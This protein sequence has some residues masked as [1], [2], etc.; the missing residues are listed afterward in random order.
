MMNVTVQ[1]DNTDVDFKWICD[2]VM[3]EMHRLGVPGVAVGIFYEGRQYL[4]GFGITS[5]ENPL[6]VTADT[7]FQIGSTT[8]TITGTIIMQLVE[9]G[10]IDLDEPVR[11]YLPTLSL[12]DKTAE[13]TVTPRHL[14]T[15]MGGWLGDFFR[16]TGN[17]D[18]SLSRYVEEMAELPQVVPVG[19]LW[20]YNN[21]G[22]GLAGRLIEVVTGKVYEDVAQELVLTPLRMNDSYFFPADVISRR[23]VVGHRNNKKTGP[24]VLRPWALA[25]SAHAVGGLCSTARDQM[26]YARFHLG[27]GTAATGQRLL[28]ADTIHAMQIPHAPANLGRQMGLSWILKDYG[29]AWAVLHGGATKGQLSA[30]QMVPTRGFAITVLTN[31]EEGGMLGDAVVARAM[32]HYLGLREPEMTYL[33]LTPDELAAYEGRYEARLSH[34]EL[35]VKKEQLMM[36]SIP[37]GGFPDKDS[38]ASPTPPPSRLAFFGPDRVVALDEPLINTKAEFIRDEEGR[39]VW[40]RT[41]R[42]HRRVE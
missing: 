5:V 9:K 22:F 3:A 12:A 8:K 1:H 14:L 34:L 10:L 36:R 2:F 27:D 37:Q 31:A 18:D 40:L 30:F 21:A 29:D 42:L 33:D 23:F 28:S 16:E 19:A 20:S 4:A 38:P 35:Y 17:G 15:H 26:R 11:H 41:S 25:R 24:E 39:I 32:Q 13:Q 7:L 6:P